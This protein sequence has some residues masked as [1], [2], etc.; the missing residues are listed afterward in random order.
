MYKTP[1]CHSSP[2]AWACFKH[3]SLSCS[4]SFI[5]TLLN[6]AGLR[7]SPR[8]REISGFCSLNRQ[9]LSIIESPNDLGLTQLTPWIR[10]GL[11]KSHQY[12]LRG[13]TLRTKKRRGGNPRTSM[14]DIMR[15]RWCREGCWIGESI[16]YTDDRGM[17]HRGREQD[18]EGIVWE[19]GWEERAWEMAGR[20]EV[21]TRDWLF[22]GGRLVSDVRPGLVPNSTKGSP[23]LEARTPY[24]C[25]HLKSH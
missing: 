11:E 12:Y 5:T 9:H 2:C 19:K 24:T 17:Y 6:I 23:T 1:T 10:K 21:D 20:G 8:P 13:R 18:K 14:G 7:R 4:S 25:F 22:S 15:A 16:G 3:V